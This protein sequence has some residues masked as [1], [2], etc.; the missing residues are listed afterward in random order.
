MVFETRVQC[1]LGGGG[2]PLRGLSCLQLSSWE[3]VGEAPDKQ[4][5]SLGLWSEAKVCCQ[6]K[7]FDRL[8]HPWSPPASGWCLARHVD[9]ELWGATS[10]CPTDLSAHSSQVGP[11]QGTVSPVVRMEGPSSPL[12]LDSG[13][14]VVLRSTSVTAGSKCKAV[15]SALRRA[16]GQGQKASGP[17]ISIP[18]TDYPQKRV[19]TE[20]FVPGPTPEAR[21]ATAKAKNGSSSLF[22]PTFLSIRIFHC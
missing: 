14:R 22:P 6:R 3:V 7:T 10:F 17:R 11:H 18:V 1:I 21:P 5:S 2:L 12:F 8:R 15:Q 19:G 20:S 13:C 16:G 9:S 4:S